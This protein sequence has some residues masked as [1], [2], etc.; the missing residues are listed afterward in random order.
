M[1]LL[2]A[3]RFSRWCRMS[4]AG[5]NAIVPLWYTHHDS[6]SLHFSPRMRSGWTIVFLS[7]MSRW[8]QTKTVSV[9]S[10]QPHSSY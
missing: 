4:F 8:S 9:G 1:T 7:C 2:R 5:A 6:V 10:L 3:W